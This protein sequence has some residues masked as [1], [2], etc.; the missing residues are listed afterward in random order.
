MHIGAF[1]TA[2][3]GMQQTQGQRHEKRP[4]SNHQTPR[5]K[6]KQTKTIGRLPPWWRALQ[7]LYIIENQAKHNWRGQFQYLYSIVGNN[8]LRYPRKLEKQ[9]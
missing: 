4:E 5:V 3:K 7:L 8:R 6:H 9:H 2:Y 1:G